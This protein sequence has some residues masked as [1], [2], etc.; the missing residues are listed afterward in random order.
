MDVD[1]YATQIMGFIAAE[2]ARG[3]P[4]A[5]SR[6]ARSESGEEIGLVV[7]YLVKAG[8]PDDLRDA[9][10]AEVR[11]RLLDQGHDPGA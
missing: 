9:V 5:S 2:Q 4:I 8:V 7:F 1:E 10:A 11:R 3:F 6:S